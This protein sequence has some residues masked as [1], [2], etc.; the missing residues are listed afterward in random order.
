RGSGSPTA[1]RGRRSRRRRG[2][3]AA[4][5]AH[6]CR[7]RI[8]QRGR[9]HQL[10][11]PLVA[12]ADLLR[13]SHRPHVARPDEGDQP[14]KPALLD[15]PIPQRERSLRRIAVA[16]VL[17]N[18]EPAELDLG[19]LARLVER[20]RL[21]AVGVPDEEAGAAH[22]PAGLAALHGE[23]PDPVLLP[24]LEPEADPALDLLARARAAVAHE[25]HHLG[26]GVGGLEVVRVLGTGLAEDEALGLDHGRGCSQRTASP[27]SKSVTVSPGVQPSRSATRCERTFAGAMTETSRSMPSPRAQ[28]RT[29][30]AASV[31]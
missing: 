7:E 11:L 22:D 21:P 27:V 18:D 31:A 26:I 5:A 28:S 29:A 13:D 9:A 15:A 12:L 30:L 1:R 17:A 19:S 16:P 24:A 4:G 23:K 25:A 6:S 2:R 14:C 3:P 10:D 20:A 8:Q